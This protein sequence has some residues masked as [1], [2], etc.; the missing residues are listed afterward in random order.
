MTVRVKLF[1]AARELAGAGEIAVDVGEGATVADVERAVLRVVPALEKL[2]S[3]A[4][5]AVDES[6]AASNAKI[7]PSSQIALIPPVSGG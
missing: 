1:A 3:H 6:F 2:V 5:W 4:R 7:G